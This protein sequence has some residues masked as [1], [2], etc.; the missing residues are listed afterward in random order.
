MKSDF[1]ACPLVLLLLVSAGCV[2]K[3]SD[4]AAEAPPAPKVEA[5]EDSNVVK[6]DQPNDF[7]VTAATEVDGASTLTATGSVSADVARQIP[8]I[9]LASGRAVEIYARLGDHVSKGQLLMRVQSSDITNAYS[10]YQK[11]VADERLTRLQF[12]RAKDLREHGAI[13]EKDLEEADNA[14]ADAKVVVNA[15]AE[16][17]HVLGADIKNPS[18][19]VDVRAPISGVITEQNITAAGPVKT[20]DNSPNLFTVTDLSEVWVV[21]DVYENDLSQIRL[22]EFA[23]IHLTAYPDVVL[24]GRISDIGP[25]LDPALRTAKVRL[26]V[27]NPGMLRIGM[28]V[29][30]LFHGLKKEVRA[31]VPSSAV[32]HLHDHDW[33]YVPETGGRFRRVAVVGGEMKGNLQVIESGIEPGQKVVS[34][35]LVLQNTVEQ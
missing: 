16:R 9:S 34:N 18:S 25:V 30:A 13:A 8:A 20:L 19:I 4:P 7:P 6:V 33:V 1:F 12:E 17:L 22:G 5:V 14:E 35:A 3:K 28:F 24:K 10:D 2:S 29:T 11:A 21:C 31:A 27:H 32:L 15:T 23:D 26:Q